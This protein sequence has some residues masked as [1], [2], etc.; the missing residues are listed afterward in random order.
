MRC[1]SRS[2]A[3][4]AVIAL[5][6]ALSAGA[7][8]AQVTATVCKDGSSSATSGRGACSGHGGVDAVASKAAKASAKS[9]KAEAKVDAKA[10]KAEAKVDAKA[11]K[12]D[13]KA[14]AKET[15]KPA[16]SSAA[17]VGC[18]DGSMSKGGRG[19]CSGHGGIKAAAA[20]AP[21]AMSKPA[22]A[23]MAKPAAPA[24]H[25]TAS[26]ATAGSGAKEDNNPVGAIAK[27]KDGLY[28]HSAHRQGA[29]SR[30]GGVAS[31]S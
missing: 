8:S 28:S 13:A 26:N 19:A 6:S 17:M 1:L 12:A 10:A 15:A 21:M 11:T 29:C 9:A 23:T 20:V 18:A 24:T 25:A 30:H 27:C 3:M 22:P 31:W 7:A 5:A 2:F 16:A 14:D 4:A